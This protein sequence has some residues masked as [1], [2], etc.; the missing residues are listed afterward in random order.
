MTQIRIG[1]A[2][3]DAAAA[4]LGEHY[5]AGRLTKTEYDERVDQ[6]WAARFE[7]DLKPL[8]ADLPHA[9]REVEPK[10]SRPERWTGAAPGTPPWGKPGP[11]VRLLPIAVLGLIAL[12][13]I[14]GTP[15]LL[16]GLFW[17]WAFTGFGHRHRRR[18]GVQ[19]WHRPS[20]D[21][22]GRAG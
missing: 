15:W 1:D 9:P 18:P 21:C 14:T 3:R 20:Q 8:F 11:V 10:T 5:A 16:F 17:L 22:S 12:V 19:Q 6:V 2:E 13:I 4:S 7:Q